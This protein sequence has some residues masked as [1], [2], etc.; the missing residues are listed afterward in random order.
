[1]YYS[2]VI[3]RLTLDYLSQFRVVGIMGPR[4]SG[5]STMIKHLLRDKY[6][7]VTFDRIENREFFYINPE[8]FIR[9]HNNKVAFDEVQQVPEL[10]SRIKVIA[11]E[12]PLDKGRFVLTG[13]GQYLLS[14]N[15]SESL[16]GRIGLITVLPFQYQ[17]TPELFRMNIVATGG[18]PEVVVGSFSNPD[19]YF[20]SYLNTYV[21][22][23]LRSM[24]NITDLNAFTLFLRLLATRAAQLLNLSDLAKETGISVTTLSRW[25]SV[26]EASY[27]IFLIRPYF[28]NLGKRLVKAPKVYFYDNGLLSYLIG[29]SSLGSWEKHDM[30]GEL[31]ENYIVAE[32]RKNFYHKGVFA[33]LFYLRTNHGDE[34]DLLIDNKNSV[35]AIEIKMTDA[36]NT[37]FHKTLEKLS[38]PQWKKEVIYSGQTIAAT[39]EIMAWNYRE[40]LQN[41]IQLY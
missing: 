37:R 1:M 15:I 38:L 35:N 18:Y 13:S 2:R 22:K 3:E 9:K 27:I 10:F 5:K 31:F 23:D 20:E 39:S 33:D 24:L 7:Y 29:A 32:I 28:Q 16:A 21:Q 11:D 26:L 34:I 8:A 19:I 14:K 30:A 4:Q 12:N 41:K 40:Y 17:E 36:Y 6:T 25:L